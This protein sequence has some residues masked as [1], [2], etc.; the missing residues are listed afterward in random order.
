M[1][2]NSSLISVIGFWI[3]L[4][5]ALN[6]YCQSAQDLWN[7]GMRFEEKFQDAE[8]LRCFMK[9]LE[10]YPGHSGALCHASKLSA[11]LGG[12][13][14]NLMEKKK[15]VMFAKDLACR[16]MAADQ[17]NADAHFHYIVALGLMAEMADS[18]VE[19]LENARI[20]KREAEFILRLDSN[21]AGVY[22]I[23]GKWHAAISGLRWVDRLIIKA[24]LGGLPEG[25]SYNESILSFQRAVRLRPDYILF[26]YGLSKALADHGQNEVALKTLEQAL[27]LPSLEPDDEIRKE[28]CKRLIHLLKS[29]K[30]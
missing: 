9:I 23:L 15:K 5:S 12:R 22:Y 26:Y 10:R 7:E 19:K 2:K 21:Y 17:L 8:A 16:A 1:K 20:I 18:P 30:S 25:A 13:L 6:A 14:D 28:N 29:P 11:Q 4:T 3:C 24:L 27:L